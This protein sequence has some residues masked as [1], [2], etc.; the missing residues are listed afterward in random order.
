M[1]FFYCDHKI[2][3]ENTPFI[4][5]NNRGL[6]LGDGCFE[7]I[8]VRDKIGVHLSDHIA[9]LR[10]A[11]DILYIP[12]PDD[13]DNA[14]HITTLLCDASGLSDAALRITVSRGI[15]KRGLHFD[16]M[17]IPTLVFQISPCPAP[18][19]SPISACISKILRNP[20]S[21]TS[22]I[23]S[24]N[25]LDNIMALDGAKRRGCHDAL[26]LNFDG[27]AVCF[28]I[29]NLLLQTHDNIYIS[30]PPSQGCIS[31][32]T[33]KHFEQ[34]VIYQNITLDMMRHARHIY[35]TN[36]LTGCVPVMLDFGLL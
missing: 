35:R 1:T 8:L 14:E 6:T 20:T 26:F 13:I 9:R 27:N 22:R 33:L 36:A 29:G 31:G 15:G 21:I 11:L 19:L 25:Y 28:T 23:K 10:Q 18:T 32:I 24:L 30:P 5:A 34:P 17:M 16:D 12:C 3:P 4:H 7:T 2:Y